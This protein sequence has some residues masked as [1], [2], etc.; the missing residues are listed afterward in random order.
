MP[1]VA[2]D[3]SSLH[4]LRKSGVQRKTALVMCQRSEVTGSAERIRTLLQHLDTTP[5]AS[6]STS[7]SLQ[8]EIQHEENP[9]K[10]GLVDI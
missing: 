6:S 9:H 4:A 7:Q 1:I 2:I 3:F 10:A 5:S 8:G